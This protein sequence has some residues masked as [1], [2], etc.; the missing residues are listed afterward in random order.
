M[1]RAKHYIMYIFAKCLACCPGCYDPSSSI[2][3][4]FFYWMLMMLFEHWNF[5]LWICPLHG[6]YSYVLSSVSLAIHMLNFAYS[7]I[8]MLYRLGT[9]DNLLLTIE[10]KIKWAD[11]MSEVDKK[12]KKEVEERLEE[13]KKTISHKVWNSFLLL[14]IIYWS[15]ISN[16][17][18]TVRL[19]GHYALRVLVPWDSAFGVLQVHDAPPPGYIVVS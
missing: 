14:F 4:L 11:S 7:I 2:F 1:Q 8:I 13:V 9:S 15:G 3:W 5:V 18:C 16:D 19:A 12:H 10:E 17:Y 6:I